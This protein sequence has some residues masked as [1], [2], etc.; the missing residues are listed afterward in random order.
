MMQL[1]EF[2][3]RRP[4]LVGSLAHSNVWRFVDA[5]P[6]AVAPDT[7]YDTID[8]EVDQDAPI[9]WCWM[10]PPGKPI[11]TNPL[12]T[13]LKTMHRELPAILDNAERPIEYYVFASRVAA[14]TALA[15]TLLS[16]P[17]VFAQGIVRQ[18]APMHMPASTWFGSMSLRL[19]GR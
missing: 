8:V 12:L 5:D 7:I 18:S 13:D 11:V 2:G 15:A 9:F 19:I 3:S 10:R 1:N 16:S 4:T 17:K 14:P 6:P